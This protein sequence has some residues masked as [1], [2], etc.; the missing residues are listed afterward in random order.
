MKIN[1]IKPPTV[2][3]YNPEGKKIGTVNEYEF[4]D[5]LIQ[6]KN[7]YVKGYYAIF[8]GEKINILEGGKVDKQPDGFFDIIE[9]QLNIIILGY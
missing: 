9:K 6:L 2:D 8:N 5:V 7:N 1:R 3:L 4:N